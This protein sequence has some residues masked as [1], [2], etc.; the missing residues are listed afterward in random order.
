MFKH[1]ISFV[2]VLVL[3]LALA[4]A[5][6]AE[7][8]GPNGIIAPTGTNPDTGNPWAPG[9]TYHLVFVVNQTQPTQNPNSAVIGVY[10]TYVQG[11]A[12]AAGI[13]TSKSVSWKVIGSTPTTDAR[14]NALVSAPVYLLD[15]STKIADG[16]A[17]MW[18]GSIANPINLTETGVSTDTWP[19][20]KQ[21]TGTTWAGFKAASGYELG[22]SQS[23]VEF[24]RS[25]N[26][27]NHWVASAFA[28]GGGSQN[29][30]RT[31]YTAAGRSYIA[32][33]QELTIIP[34]P[35]TFALAALGLLS[36][37]LVGWRWRKR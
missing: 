18:D 32:L 24:G 21:F 13:G 14:D 17:D 1:T 35:S 31:E 28:A 37:G 19:N 6:Q 27:N 36:L 29:I 26:T 33:S 22:G 25:G 3:V 16:F 7:L 30:L 9:D 10:N 23:R 12:D 2:A 34:E 4:P 8:T 11:H 15:G 5:A 20:P